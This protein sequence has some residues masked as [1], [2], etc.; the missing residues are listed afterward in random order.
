[1]TQLDTKLSTQ[2]L[3]QYQ[4]QN[5]QELQ[6]SVKKLHQ[7]RLY[8]LQPQT[9]LRW[10]GYGFL[11]LSLFDLIEILYPPQFMNPAW[12]F[13]TLGQL[14][15]RVPV[16]LIGFALVIA[17]GRD[18]RSR[19]ERPFLRVLS[20]STLLIALV[21]YLGIP[22]GI[23]DTIRLNQQLNAQVMPRLE[24]QMADVQVQVQAVKDQVDQ[25]TTATDLQAL[26][27]QLELQG[28]L[29]DIQSDAQLSNVKQQI[30]V[31]L[32][33]QVAGMEYQAKTE[34]AN[35]QQQLWMRS[36]KWNLG[37]LVSGTLFFLLWKETGWARSSR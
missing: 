27:S 21:F 14:V 16:P 4:N 3:D 31:T 19:I 33:N 35:Q 5:I 20:W 29:P 18:M 15:E 32:D 12:E 28:Q 1:M 24:Q 36:V 34:L 30:V 26:L 9:V 6:Q 25:A 10:I 2:N 13:E 37:A 23:F 17:G 11:L 8:Q 22:L 7:L